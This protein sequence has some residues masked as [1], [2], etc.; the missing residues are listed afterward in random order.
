MQV[1]RVDSIKSI[2]LI[3]CFK[4]R[5]LHK[6]QIKNA[7]GAEGNKAKFKE[8]LSQDPSLIKNPDLLYYAIDGENQEMIK[9][10]IEK[11]A[12]VN[13]VRNRFSMISPLIYASSKI[14]KTDLSA[15]VA[16]LLEKGA[17]INYQDRSGNTALIAALKFAKKLSKMGESVQKIMDYMNFSVMRVLAETPSLNKEIRDKKGKLAFDYLEALQNRLYYIEVYHALAPK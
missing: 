5:K 9:Y 3:F 10:V 2:Q 4:N 17:D 16:L 8:L 12:D 6:K 11:G 1:Y 14:G 7:L 15:I 13:Q